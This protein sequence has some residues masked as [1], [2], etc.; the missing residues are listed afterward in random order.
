M[1]NATIDPAVH[2]GLVA[3]TTSDIDRLLGFYQRLLGMQLIERRGDRALL[4]A[5]ASQPLLQLVEDPQ[6][7]PPPRRAPGLYHF[8]ILFPS[9]P[10]LGQALL[11]LVENNYSL[12]GAADHLVSEALYLADPDGN[13][14][15]LY[16]DRPASDWPYSSGQLQMGTEPLSLS[17]LMEEAAE[18]ANGMPSG[19]QIGHV[20]LKV[21]NIPAADDFYIRQLGMDLMLHFGPKAGFVSA[22]GYHH[23]IGYNTW[24]SAGAEPPPPG[25]AGLRYFSLLMPSQAVLDEVVGR[26][27]D[28]GAAVL[29]ADD[30]PDLPQGSVFTRDP[31]GNRLLLTVQYF[32]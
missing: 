2:P 11:R 10:L 4:G 18:P 23:H 21:A 22:G 17:S 27:K 5:E 6:A 24:E 30:E 9:R 1:S 8:A 29:P 25:S 20:H 32:S 16:R 31:S 12:Q 19:T 3:L 28:G 14:I 7:P 26:L 15:E 13:G